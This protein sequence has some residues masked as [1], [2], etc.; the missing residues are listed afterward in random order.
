LQSKKNKKEKKSEKRNIVKRDKTDQKNL[1]KV[2]KQVIGGFIFD[3]TIVIKH[4]P[5]VIVIT[6]PK[7]SEKSEELEMDESGMFILFLIG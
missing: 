7:F 3:S 6:G 4:K 5:D 2:L 1:S